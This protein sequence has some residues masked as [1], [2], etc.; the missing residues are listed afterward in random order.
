MMN[1]SEM[2]DSDFLSFLY[3]ERDRENS[4][5]QYHG[6]SNWAL[7][8]AIITLLCTIY[9]TVK[10]NQQLDWMKVLSYWSGL[11]AFYLAYHSWALFFSRN[12][13]YNYMRV[14]LLQDVIPWSEMGLIIISAVVFLVS[15]FI[16]RKITLVFW[17]WCTVLV[18]QLVATIVAVHKRDCLV[19]PFAFSFYF[20]SVKWNIVYYSIMGLLFVAIWSWTFKIR[21]AGFF[22]SEFEM[23]VCFASLFILAHLFFK[24]NLENKV[25]NHFDEILD[26]YLYAF[27]TKE[28]TYKKILC[29]RMGYGILEVCKDDLQT[30]QESI[31]DYDNKEEEIGALKNKIVRGEFDLEEFSLYLDKIRE[32]LD[33]IDKTVRLSKRLVNRGNE[34]LT[35]DPFMSQLED[36][37]KIFETNNN[38]LSKAESAQSSVKE[39]YVLMKKEL[40][41]FKAKGAISD[42]KRESSPE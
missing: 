24:L 41:S 20:P 40:T 1:V 32:V 39:V 29:N 22:N 11:V 15:F 6:W 7:T 37:S 4:I 14:K 23:G 33:S 8:G 12:R 38:I 18:I 30:V 3:A 19:P 35:M 28:E 17:L 26:R 10:N 5:S 9:L 21:S 25:V 36:L 13:G 42:E 27:E 2:S 31:I 16:H 34:I